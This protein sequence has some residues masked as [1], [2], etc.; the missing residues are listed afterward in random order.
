LGT[1]SGSL[2]APV[3]RGVDPEALG[4]AHLDDVRRPLGGALGVGVER[5]AGPEAL[6]E[7]EP[8]VCSSTWSIRTRPG[9]I[10]PVALDRVDDE[11]RALELVL[12]V[13]RVDEDELVVLGGEPICSSRIVISFLEFLLSPISPM[14][15]TP[16]LSR[17]SRDEVDHL[18]GEGGVLGFLGVD[19]E[20]AVVVDAVRGGALGL[21]LV[22]AG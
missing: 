20:P 4:A 12:E 22:S 16:G 6:V 9:S 15:R 3:A 21:G 7:H 19:A 18:A 1:A 17:N 11:L 8:T 10:V 14:P 2:V 13:G 5:H